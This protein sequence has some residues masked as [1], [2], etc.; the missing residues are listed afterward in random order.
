M[1]VPVMAALAMM[2]QT[3]APEDE[4][5]VFARRLE[6]VSVRLAPDANGKLACGMNQSSGDAKIDAK[7]CRAAARCVKQGAAG[8]DAMKNCIDKTKPGL[9]RDFAAN[10]RAGQS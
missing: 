5:T 10:R 3:A 1:I 2:A 9:L 8:N 6:S 7:L 4:I